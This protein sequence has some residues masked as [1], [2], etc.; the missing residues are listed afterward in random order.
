MHSLGNVITEKWTFN[1]K[2]KNNIKEVE[3]LL[4]IERYQW[5]G[6]QDAVKYINKTKSYIIE[7]L[8]K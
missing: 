1:A 5:N 3:I 7:T 8:R 2:G 6:K 4:K